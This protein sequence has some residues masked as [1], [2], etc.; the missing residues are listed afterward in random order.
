MSEMR[1]SQL[2]E[3]TGVPATTLRFYESSGL[4]PADRAT[5]GYRVYGQDAVER[6]AFI[7]AAKLVG[8][9]LEE[10]AELLAVWESGA[11]HEVKA[12]LRPRV[13]S[14]LAAAEER[15]AELSAFR[16]SL[17]AALDHLDALPDRSGRCDPPC[18]FLT[19]ADS[20]ASARSSARRV[21]VAMASSRRAAEEQAERW[22]TAPVAC[23]LNGE[24]R[25]ERINDWHRVI[26]GASRRTIRDGL[27]LTLP[28]ARVQEV[29]ALAA[30]EQ[31]CCTFFD[32]RLHLDCPDLHLE[33]RART[34]ATA[35]LVELFATPS[36]PSPAHLPGRRAGQDLLPL[37][38]ES[39]RAVARR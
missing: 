27:R 15:S 22:R 16:E 19:P 23:S 24:Q 10:I 26:S 18:G 30:A 11:C 34:D 39:L 35:Q 14:R 4:L 37:R 2:A 36:Y 20:A 9:P 5:S 8:L 1:I 31:S 12:D 3:R 13:A 6:L 32:F 25:G 17:R 33:V 21:D 7:G 38:T 28:V 29:A